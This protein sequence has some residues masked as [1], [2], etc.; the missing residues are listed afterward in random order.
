MLTRFIQAAMSRASYEIL[1]DGSLYG[2]ISACEGVF[3]DAPTL[4]DCRKLLQEVLEEW[5]MLGLR[6]GHTIPEI[7]GV[8]LDISGEA[9]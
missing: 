4:E 5:I 9:A 1:S 2:E 8:R 3:A 6:L 7:D